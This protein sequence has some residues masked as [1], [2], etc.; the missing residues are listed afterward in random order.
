M[1]DNRNDIFTP[2]CLKAIHEAFAFAKERKYEFV[3]IDNLMIFIAQTEYGRKIF[4]AMNLNVEDFKSEVIRYLDENVSKLNTNYLN[5][6]IQGTIGLEHTLQKAAVLQKAS[7]KTLVDEG[8]LLVALFELNASDTFTLSYFDYYNVSRFDIMTYI[9]HS[10]KKD[11]AKQ[12]VKEEQKDQSKAFLKK[13][14]KLLNKTVATGDVDPIIGREDEIDKVISILAQRRKNNP[15]LVGDPGVGKTAIAEGLAKK[16]VAGQVPESLKNLNIYSLDLTG[17]VAGTKYRGDFEERLKGVIKDVMSDQNVVLFIDEIHTLIGAGASNSP[18]DASNI[19]KPYLSSGEIKVIG[20]TTYTEYR[21]YFEKD[22]ALARRFQKVDVNEPSETEA[23]QILSGIKGHFESFHGVEYTSEAINTA[24]KLTVKYMNDRRLP[25][26]AIDIIDMSGAKMKLKGLKD[27]KLITEKE[28]AE[29]VANVLKI[30]VTQLQGEEKTRLRNLESV[31]KERIF[32]QNEAI[33]TVVNGILLSRIVS[34][35]K[36]VGSFLLAGPSGVGKTE[37]SKQI[38]H[39]MGIPL[40]RFDMSEYMERHAVSRLI[41]APPGYVGHD[42]GGQLIEAVRKSPHC[43]LLIDEIEKAHPDI[44]NILLQIM[45]YGALT[46]SQGNKADLKNVILMITTN[47]GA[48]EISKATIGFT[49]HDTVKEDRE[50]QIKKLFP[51]EFIGRLDAIVQFNPLNEEN[52]E[53]VV[54]KHLIALQNDLLDKKV[55]TIFTEELYQYIAKNGFDEKLGARPIQR[56]IEK[57]IAQP[58]AKEIIFGQLENGGEVTISVKDEAVVFNFVHLYG[59]NEIEISTDLENTILPEIE[60]K[61]KTTRTRKIA[62][63]IN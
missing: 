59:Q 14:T 8:Y 29:T 40:V 34:K 50:E 31:L 7:S 16:I 62:N 17:L 9:A 15:V 21:K 3:T 43:V 46:D 56:F 5:D 39:N 38:A 12:T 41:G 2:S 51:P 48:R 26:K 27:N 24:V 19:L 42:E 37:L 11:P 53:K 52:V 33:D 44:F 54:K 36:P 60:K 61:P 13:F 23:I 57:S 18:M 49:K 28:I 6:T 25:D 45:D 20:A 63:K 22:A 32:G 47:A 30:P 55:V 10:I 4:E 1:E 35:D 58:L